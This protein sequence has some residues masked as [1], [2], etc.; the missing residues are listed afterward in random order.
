M[1]S[2]LIDRLVTELGYA[3]LDAATLDPFLT[4]QTHSV[5]FFA[6]D[7][8]R[9]P[10]SNDVAVVLPELVAALGAGV[11]PAVV[12]AEAETELQGRF[13]FGA[14]PALVFLRGNGYLGA[15]TRMQ[16]WGD[17]VAEARRLLRAEPVRPP[18]IGI[19]VSAA[20][21]SCH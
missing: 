10:E 4:A 15:I 18:T 12:A 11:T 20:T 21:T 1:S 5:L 13:G 7:P 8:Q 3:R 19:P 17:Y 6:G 2:P 14:W 9:Y 16:D